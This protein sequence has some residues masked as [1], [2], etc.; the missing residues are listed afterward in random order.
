ME[1]KKRRKSKER[2][3]K[4][5]RENEIACSQCSNSDCKLSNTYHFYHLFIPPSCPPINQPTQLLTLAHSAI[6]R[7]RKCLRLRRNFGINLKIFETFLFTLCGHDSLKFVAF[8][9]DFIISPLICVLFISDLSFFHSIPYHC[10]LF[11]TFL[12]YLG[13]AT[14][15]TRVMF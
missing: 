7:R 1:G 15:L 5:G 4:G 8:L 3:T 12:S 9:F 10:F 2:T 11:K 6:R 13:L 14:N